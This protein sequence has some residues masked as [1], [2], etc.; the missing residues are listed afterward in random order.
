MIIVTGGAGFIG[1]AIVSKLNSKGFDDILIVDSL[2]DSDKW[3]NLV[4][5]KF[6]DFI[7]KTKFIELVEN[8]SLLDE[9]TAI[10]HMGACSSTTEKNADYLMENNYHYTRKPKEF[11]LNKNESP[12]ADVNQRVSNV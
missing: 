3:K 1:S 9:I 10:I 11:V 6:I 5:L 12:S 7:H 8:N 4:N 2:N